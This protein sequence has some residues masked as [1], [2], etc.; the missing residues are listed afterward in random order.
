MMYL[1]LAPRSIA[2]DG[3]MVELSEKIVKMMT[4]ITLI[5]WLG[6]LRMNFSFY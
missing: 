6:F 4:I 3:T 1:D 2:V 5:R